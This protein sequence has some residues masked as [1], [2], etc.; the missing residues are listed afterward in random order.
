[1]PITPSCQ[2]FCFFTNHALK[3]GPITPSRPWG[4]FYK[5]FVGYL[6]DDYKIKPLHIILPKTSKCVKRYDCQTKWMYYLTEDDDLLK[7]Y[8]TFWN[9]VSSDTK[10]E[11]DSKHF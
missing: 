5:N 4:C 7:K 2:L 9:K 3:K 8:N 1:M 10:K 11:F 6:C